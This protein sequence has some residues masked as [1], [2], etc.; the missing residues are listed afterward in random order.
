MNTSRLRRSYRC[1]REQE[2]HRAE[3]AVMPVQDEHIEPIRRWRNAQI[4]VLR[5]T[6]PLSEHEQLSYYER[7]IW[8]SMQLSEPAQILFVLKHR[9]TVLGYGGLVHI[10]WADRRA[11]LSFLLDPAIARDPGRYELHFRAHIA[12][13]LEVA[14][15]DLGFH[16]LFTETFDVR[17]LHVAVLESTGFV[18]EGTLRDHV[19]I[20]DDFVN[21]LIHGYLLEAGNAPG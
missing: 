16:R 7:V 21:S 9:A 11:E 18:R 19:R 1:L 2:R 10:A 3:H 4:D 6:Q 15:S 17:P 13:M 12:L 14:G 8:P 20:G 5:Q